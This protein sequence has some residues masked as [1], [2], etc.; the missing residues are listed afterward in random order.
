[1]FAQKGVRHA[2]YIEAPANG[3]KTFF[4]DDNTEIGQAEQ[5]AKRDKVMRPVVDHFFARFMADIEAG[6]GDRLDAKQAAAL[7]AMVCPGN[8]PSGDGKR[9]RSRPAS[10]RWHRHPDS[11]GRADRGQGPSAGGSLM[12]TRKDPVAA[13]RAKAEPGTGRG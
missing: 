1:M 9:R 8:S 10:R 13:A 6:R 4:A 3:V 11:H 5:D 2:R 12:A 7:M